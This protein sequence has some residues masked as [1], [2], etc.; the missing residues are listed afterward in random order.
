MD[1]KSKFDKI[2]DVEKYIIDSIDK[3]IPIMV[4]WA[5]LEGNWQTIIGIDTC[6]TEDLYDDV[7]IMA[8]PYDVTD[9]YQDVYYTIWQIFLYVERRTMYAKRYSIH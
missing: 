3:G 6:G 1:I 2:E 4:H 5:D 9:H 8:D 7:L